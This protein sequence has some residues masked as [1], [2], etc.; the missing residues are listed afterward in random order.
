MDWRSVRTGAWMVSEGDLRMASGLTETT[1]K[2]CL[3][4]IRTR[5]E[6][7]TSVGTAAQACANTGS[8]KKAVEIALDI[9]QSIYEAGILLNAMTI[10]I[11]VDE[12]WALH[13]LT[14]FDSR[15]KR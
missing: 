15:E 1:I 14:I 4:Q 6:Q 11:R 5:L 7:A 10:I 8:V 13:T 12:T 2:T 9:E 3:Q